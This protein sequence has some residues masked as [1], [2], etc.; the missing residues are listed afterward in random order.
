MTVPVTIAPA[1][2]MELFRHPIAPAD[3]EARRLAAAVMRGDERAFRELYDR[4]HD[5]LFRLV[6]VLGHGD[7]SLA[8]EIVQ[9][10]MLT[11]ARK[12]RAVESEAH[13]WHWLARVARQ[14]L[15][16]A[17]RRQQCDALLVSMADPPELAEVPDPEPVLARCLNVAVAALDEDEKQL[18]ELFYQEE[19]TH[20]DIATQRNTTSKAISSRLERIRAKLRTRTL[21]ELSHD[22]GTPSSAP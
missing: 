3:A 22:T 8:H 13:L 14:Q 21:K 5:R 15:G 20:Q 4:Y 7:E 10:V 19:M 1:P 11:A 17:R 6:L 18:L 12:L 9:S 16:K 2:C